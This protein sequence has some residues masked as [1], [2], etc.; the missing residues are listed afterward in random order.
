MLV[1]TIQ[2]LKFYHSIVAESNKFAI[3]ASDEWS[4]VT[5]L[6]KLRSVMLIACEWK[7]EKLSLVYKD[8]IVVLTHMRGSTIVTSVHKA[9]SG[10]PFK[11][12]A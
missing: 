7:P 3:F 12:V 8:S 1:K 2:L 4:L 6:Q 10:P 5:A 9:F 11:D